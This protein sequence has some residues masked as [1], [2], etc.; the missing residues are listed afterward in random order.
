MCRSTHLHCDVGKVTIC[1]E[2][3]QRSKPMKCVGCDA[4]CRLNGIIQL[5]VVSMEYS[6]GLPLVFHVAR[7]PQR[8]ELHG[9]WF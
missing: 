7:V 4:R 9:Q 2:F 3:H 1:T 6:I 5:S 8:A